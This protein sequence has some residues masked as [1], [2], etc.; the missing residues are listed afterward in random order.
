MAPQ[1]S[2]HEEHCGVSRDYDRSIA[3][4][5]VSSCASSDTIRSNRRDIKKD[6]PFGF[7][8]S[9]WDQ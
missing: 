4:R 6:R 5:H 8:R 1:G 2:C 9:K 7:G 3:R